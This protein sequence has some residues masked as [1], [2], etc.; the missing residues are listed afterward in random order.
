M[1][2]SPIGPAPS[3]QETLNGFGYLAFEILILPTILQWCNAQLDTPLNLAE[4]NFVYYLINFMAMLVIFHSYLG[5]NFSEAL[6]HPI[7]LCQA[8]ILGLAAYYV[9][10]NLMNLLVGLLV[11]GFTNFNDEAIAVMEGSN[12]FLMLIGTVVLVPP[13]E[14]CFFRG[15][16]FRNLYGKNKWAAY[17]VSTLAFSILHILGYIGLYSPMELAMAVLQY[18]P[19]GIWLGWVYTKAGTIAAPIWMHAAVNFFAVSALR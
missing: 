5:R 11:P 10:A 19:A 7:L 1:K 2:H 15:L 17:G 6:R 8:V 14:E 16:V 9:S 4:T 3:R 13:A 12:S 18:L